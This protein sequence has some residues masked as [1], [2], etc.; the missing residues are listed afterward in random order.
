MKKSKFKKYYSRPGVC[1][2]SGFSSMKNSSSGKCYRYCSL[3]GISSTFRCINNF[4]FTGEYRESWS[5]S[6]EHY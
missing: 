5:T 4:A 3:S 1:S 6:G 2:K